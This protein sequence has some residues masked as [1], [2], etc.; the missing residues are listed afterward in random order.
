M[1]NYLFSLTPTFTQGLVIGQLSILLLLAVILKYLFLDT[2][3]E[4]P[5]EY[6]QAYE[7]LP[8]SGLANERV[9]LRPNARAGGNDG[10]EGVESAEWFN[11]IV[12]QVCILIGVIRQGLR[13]SDQTFSL[14]CRDI[15]SAVAGRHIRS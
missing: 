2:K 12:Q 4:G 11:L 13:V 5:G 14:D 1:A 10:G 3:N 6:A 15:S 9:T 7:S 8:A